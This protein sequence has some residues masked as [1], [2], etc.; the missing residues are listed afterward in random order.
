MY[1]YPA[2]KVSIEDNVIYVKKYQESF[3]IYSEA[4]LLVVLDTDTMTLFKPIAYI[5]VD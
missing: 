1:I 4:M 2:L 3:C 5:S